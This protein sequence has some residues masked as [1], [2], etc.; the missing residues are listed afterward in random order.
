MSSSCHRSV[1]SSASYMVADGESESHK[2]SALGMERSPLKRRKVDGNDDADDGNYLL[3]LLSIVTQKFRI[4]KMFLNLSLIAGTESTT[5]SKNKNIDP[6]TATDSSLSTDK[7]VSDTNV[8]KKNVSESATITLPTTMK[9]SQPTATTV[10][11]T[12]AKL[13]TT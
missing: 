4:L 9:P 11:P 12:T 10:T 2:L 5:I 3:L 7:K 13:P 1:T 8:S 6:T